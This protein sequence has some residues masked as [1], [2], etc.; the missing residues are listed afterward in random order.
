M[1]TELLLA[2]LILGAAACGDP[3]APAGGSAAASGSGAKPHMSAAKTATA[4]ATATMT[5]SAA[6]TASAMPDAKA[7]V[8]TC[9]HKV[10]ATCKEYLG[11]LPADVETSCAGK[12]KKGELAKGSTPCT[13]EN[14]IGTC[15]MKV[16]ELMEAVHYYK[17]AG[18]AE[19]GLKKACEGEKGTWMAEAAAA[20]SA[21][22]AAGSAAPA[23][24]SA[25][26]K[27]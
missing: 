25:A 21:S 4:T 14:A 7:V 2:T 3:P 9:T 13:H 20:G 19:A 12:D 8:G 27:K 16:G 18:A 26:P 17:K 5:A 6:P 22:A 15:E 24:G 11:T 10:E 23:A 1:R